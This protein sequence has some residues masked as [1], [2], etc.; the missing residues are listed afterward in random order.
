MFCSE[1]S[2]FVEEGISSSTLPFLLILSGGTVGPSPNPLCL[3]SLD[4]RYQTNLLM[5][6]SVLIS[7]GTSRSVLMKCCVSSSTHRAER[8][9]SVCILTQPG[10]HMP[11]EGWG[12]RE[13][14]RKEKDPQEILLFPLPSNPPLSKYL[15]ILVISKSIL[16]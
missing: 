10:L 4:F 9:G 2:H 15:P 12:E 11:A 5:T 6:K 13:E 1:L 7:K 14:G 8:G 16:V 3:H